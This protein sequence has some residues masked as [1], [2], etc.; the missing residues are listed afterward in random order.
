MRTGQISQM[1][2]NLESD[3]FACHD[4]LGPTAK[5]A[6]VYLGVWLIGWGRDQGMQPP[7]SANL[8]LSGDIPD[9]A[10]AS[11]GTPSSPVHQ[12]AALGLAQKRLMREAEPANSG[13]S[14]HTPKAQQMQDMLDI[15]MPS[16]WEHQHRQVSACVLPIPGL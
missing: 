1:C 16:A 12:G 13:H 15:N 4:L 8:Y 2:L 14:G 6:L 5:D 10:M 3:P 7:I 11:Q 9:K